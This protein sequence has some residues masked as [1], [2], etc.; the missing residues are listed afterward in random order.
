[1]QM[2]RDAYVVFFS[3]VKEK[4]QSKRMIKSLKFHAKARCC[5]WQSPSFGGVWGGLTNPPLSPTSKSHFEA[6]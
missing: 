4:I 5:A 1:M 2:R 3:A 6:Q